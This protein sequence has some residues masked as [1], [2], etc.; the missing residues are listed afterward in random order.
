MN[1]LI[2]RVQNASISM[3][4]AAP[5]A[6]VPDKQR[7]FTTDQERT[8]FMLQQEANNSRS[9]LQAVRSITTI[10]LAADQRV[11]DL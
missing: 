7:V 2:A 4:A 5:P 11:E 1:N 3:P 6:R 10:A 8:A 9:I